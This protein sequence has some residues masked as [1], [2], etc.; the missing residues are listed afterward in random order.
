MIPTGQDSLNTRSTLEAGG[1][2]YAYYS[3]QKASEALGDVSRL[4][5]QARV[6][7][8]VVASG[9]VGEVGAS[10]AE[11]IACVSHRLDLRAG[12]LIGVTCIPD[13]GVAYGATVEVLIER[14]GKLIGCPIAGKES[15]V[16]RRR[17]RRRP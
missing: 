15:A 9:T 8:Q 17:D 4:R 10:L 7:G 16:W 6:E 13:R 12:D 14:L 5:T 1:K 3:L 11:G 2:K